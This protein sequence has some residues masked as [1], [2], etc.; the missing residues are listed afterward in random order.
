MCVYNLYRISVDGPEIHA[1]GYG[2]I[3]RRKELNKW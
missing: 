1:V 2:Q 3:E